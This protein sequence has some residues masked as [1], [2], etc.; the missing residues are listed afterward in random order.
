MTTDLQLTLDLADLVEPDY[1]PRMT[2]AEKFEQF[3][4]MNPWV[5]TALESL[6]ADWLAHGH[7]KVGVK[8]LAEIVRWQY[9]RTTRGSSF[10]LDNSLVSR[11]ARLL[12]ERHPD[13]PIETRELRAA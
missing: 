12:L 11:Y 9:G 8:A 3:H 13:W 7:S 4:R 10:K 6:A 2:I 1:S 5:Y